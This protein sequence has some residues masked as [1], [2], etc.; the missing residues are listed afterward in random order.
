[1]CD[2][3]VHHQTK[4]E[5]LSLTAQYVINGKVKTRVLSTR[6]TENKKLQN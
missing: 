1:V 3:W 2:H 6:V 4:N 5:Y